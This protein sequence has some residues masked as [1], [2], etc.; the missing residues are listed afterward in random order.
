MSAVDLISEL[1]PRAMARKP[2]IVFP[3]GDDPRIVDA[4]VA[5]RRLGVAQPVLVGDP[6]RI[7]AS[8]LDL[9]GIEVVS[10]QPDADTLDAYARNISDRLGFSEKAAKRQLRKPLNL[11]ALMVGTGEVA[12]MVAGLNHTTEDVIMA[13]QLFIGLA[14]GADIASSYFVMTIPGWS[15]GVDGRLVFADC[16]VVPNPTA[17]ELASIA[18]STADSVRSLLGWEPRV[19]LISFS[20]KGSAIHP[21]V[22]KVVSALALA[23]AAESGLLIDGELQIDAA[24]VPEVAAKKVEG[25]GVL[26]GSANVLVFPDLDAGN[27]AYKLVQ[28]LARADAYGPVLQGFARPVSD[29]SRGASVEDILGCTV[30]VAAQT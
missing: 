26:G 29:L 7:R 30:I 25:G 18:R 6:D 28:R 9:S 5:A 24:L 21:D 19:A 15:G 10:A 27:A 22:D 13:S 8:S 12:G 2:R 20:T 23:K 4:A 1:Q 16:G 11:A 17:A 3:E 14:E